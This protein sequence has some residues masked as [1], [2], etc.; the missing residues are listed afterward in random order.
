MKILCVNKFDE[1]SYLAVKNQVLNDMR[2]TFA[3][4][5]IL[6]YLIGRPGGCS[7]NI[8]HLASQNHSDK[9]ALTSTLK[10]LKKLGYLTQNNACDMVFN[11]SV[12]GSFQ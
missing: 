5:G 7:V 2:T 9:K 8:D 6:F 10:E 4:K 1:K 3:A 12:K 11:L